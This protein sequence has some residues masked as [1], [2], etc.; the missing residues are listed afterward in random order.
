MN[1]KREIARRRKRIREFEEAHA[2]EAARLTRFAAAFKTI[3]HVCIKALYSRDGAPHDHRLDPVEF[4]LRH[5]WESAA[6]TQRVIQPFLDGFKEQERSRRA[7]ERRRKH[8][9][10]HKGA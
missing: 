5:I 3:S 7:W 1:S 9:R 6:D 4:L 10:K 8:Q 2:K